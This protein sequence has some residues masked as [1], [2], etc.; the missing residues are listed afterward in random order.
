MAW[1]P[2]ALAEEGT[3]VAFSAPD[4]GT[5]PAAVTHEAFHDPAGARLR[6]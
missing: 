4:G 5:V 1:V 6:S 3:R 2:V